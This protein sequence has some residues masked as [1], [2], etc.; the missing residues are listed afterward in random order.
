VRGHRGRLDPGLD[1]GSPRGAVARCCPN[2][3][4]R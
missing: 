1:G 3:G 4:S 2:R